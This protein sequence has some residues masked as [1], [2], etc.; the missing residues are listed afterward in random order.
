MLLMF[1]WPR[2]RGVREARLLFALPKLAGFP[3]GR[4]LG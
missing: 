3:V 4:L 1:V 2:V